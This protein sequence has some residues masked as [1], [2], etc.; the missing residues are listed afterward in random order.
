MSIGN[1]ISELRKKKGYTQEYIA[2][3]LGVS[4]QAVS[5]WEQD[6]TCP[7]TKNLI[8]LSDLLE[9]TVEY[10]TTGKTTTA[11]NPQY[12]IRK[13]LYITGAILFV[14]AVILQFV[15]LLTG[16]Y[17]EMVQIGFAGIPFLWYG[18]SPMAIVLM[19]VSAVFVILGI[20]F[21]IVAYRMKKRSLI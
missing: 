14:A 8:T 1:R 19:S 12:N 21:F 9:S 10:L 3:Q 18:S 20:I 7:D 15:G 5:K 13:P 2:E 4:R 17:T 11:Q 16:E 6:Q